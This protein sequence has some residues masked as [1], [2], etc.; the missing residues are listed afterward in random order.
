MSANGILGRLKTFPSFVGAPN[1]LT[2]TLSA[3]TNKLGFVFKA[4][5]TDTIT[6]I[7]IRCSTVNSPPTYRAF[8]SSV[9]SGFPNGGELSGGDFVPSAGWLWVALDAGV[10]VAAG[11]VYAIEIV[12]AS[13]TIGASN[14]AVF[15]HRVFNLE[16]GSSWAHPYPATATTGAYSRNTQNGLP[17]FALKSST[18]VYGY[19]VSDAN[20]L[21][22]S[23]AG[24]AA[25]KF[26]IPASA[27][28]A[29]SVR[30]ISLS[31]GPP[32][33]GG[34]I[35]F[36]IW[37]SA[38]GEVRGVTHS[39]DDLAISGSNRYD[40]V[41]IPF[42]PVT[43]TTGTVYYGGFEYVDRTAYLNYVEVGSADD[44]NAYPGGSAMCVAQWNGSSWSESTARRAGLEL[45][46][47]SITPS[48]GG[49]SSGTRVSPFVG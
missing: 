25:Q 36:G 2:T 11:N 5:K 8:L 19:P 31:I 22:V 38:G 7:G 33:I 23:S 48:S 41:E 34:S 43:L 26:V 29:V 46:T 3:S 44:L 15:T 18:A 37:N 13:G 21:T 49:G 47:D 32:N 45:L 27:G 17:V 16:Q 9:A 6:H 14:N 35:K 12:Y 24:I 28:S 42:D 10:S 40:R 1:I 30:G 39:T 4:W 20:T